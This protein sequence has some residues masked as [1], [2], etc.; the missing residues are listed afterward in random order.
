M[1]ALI[2]YTHPNPAS[3]NHAIYETAKRTLD[4]AGYAVECRELYAER[5]E[6]A[7][8]AADFE[9][10][11]GARV[12]ADIEREQHLIAKADLLVF[13]YPVWW[14]DRPALLKGW[15][16]RVWTRGFAFD[17]GADGRVGLLAGKQAVV[18][19]T[20]GAPLEAYAEDGQRDAIVWPMRDG[21][22]RFCGL[23]VPI[24]ETFHAVPYVSPAERA[25]MLKQVET[26]LAQLCV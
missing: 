3:F 21:T 22:L 10:F 6:V 9:A 1:N 16:D 15:I 24:Y 2:V 25:A 19:Q 5:F 14:Y 20:T 17:Y 23:E 26:S 18:F 11:A 12:P 7:L 13:I 8:D 4:Q